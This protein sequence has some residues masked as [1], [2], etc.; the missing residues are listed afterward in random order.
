MTLKFFRD[1]ADA[2]FC[3]HENATADIARMDSSP[4]LGNLANVMRNATVL[5][6]PP[7][8]VMTV[9]TNLPSESEQ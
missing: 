3:Y 9:T 5:L 4:V 2:S 7:E 1:N 6:P 8:V